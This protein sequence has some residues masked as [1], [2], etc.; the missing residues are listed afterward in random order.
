MADNWLLGLSVSGNSNAETREN[1]LPDGQT[2]RT[3]TQR[4]NRVQ[5]DVTPFVR[6]YWQFAPVQVFA[7]AGLSVGIVGLRDNTLTSNGTTQ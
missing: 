3:F 7:G 5:V 2:L 4:S 6:R 1:S